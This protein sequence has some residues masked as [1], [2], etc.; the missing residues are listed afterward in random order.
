MARITIKDLAKRLNI[1]PST[2]SRALRDRP[3][4]SVELKLKIKNLAEKL[5]YKPNYLAINLRSGKSHTIGLIIPEISMFFF[6]SVIKAI[7]E[8]S[9]NRG[10]NLLVLHSNDSLDREIENAE[11]CAHAGV[12]GILVS[13]T[14]Q[15]K[16]IEHFQELS[17]AGVPIVYF[18]KVLQNTESHKVVI[19][20]EEAAALAVEQLLLLGKTKNRVCG[21]FGDSRLSITQDR[22][23]GFKD[24]LAKAGIA[25]E[26]EN[27]CHALSSSDAEKHF[28]TLWAQNKRPDAL[29]IMSDEILSGVVQAI[30]RLQITIPKDLVLV[31]LSDGFLPKMIGTP[32]PYVETSG[33]SLGKTASILLFN[34]I[35]GMP[36]LPDTH[37][38]ET[39]FYGDKKMW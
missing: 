30:N 3:D 17:Y 23:K 29:F 32:V 16:D 15:S 27:I 25:A 5:G 13:L 14:R 7:E 37:H 11:I 22:V 18:D 35:A 10:Y 8:E 33:Y 2:V 20:G 26:E 24:T 34:L 36:I 1:N 39:T 9:H 4:V 31:A 19:P 6:P 38:I 12:D 28:L 21:I